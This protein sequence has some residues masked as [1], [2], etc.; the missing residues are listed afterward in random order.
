M[1]D[2]IAGQ[3]D[4]IVFGDHGRL[5]YLDGDGNL[6][7]VFGF[8]GR[9]DLIDSTVIDSTWV[10]SRDLNEGVIEKSGRRVRSLH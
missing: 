4:D 10:I 6:L 1:D 7:S 2:I 5:Q 3:A 9:D 8:G